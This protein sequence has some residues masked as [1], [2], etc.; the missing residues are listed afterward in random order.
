[1]RHVVADFNLDF[2]TDVM[3][4]RRV[5][6]RDDRRHYDDNDDNADGDNGSERGDDDEKD[7]WA[8]RHRALNEALSGCA[9]CCVGSPLVV[10]SL[11]VGATRD[12]R[13][14]QTGR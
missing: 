7:A 13:Q 11:N 12:A 10:D 2:Y 8:T 4:L 9:G 3:D 6:E 14:H 5:A 1:M